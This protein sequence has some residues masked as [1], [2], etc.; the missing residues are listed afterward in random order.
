MATATDSRTPIPTLADVLARVD[1]PPGR[2]VL[3]GAIGAGTVEDVLYLNDHHGRLCELVDGILV[4]KAMGYEESGL[5]MILGHLLLVY[6]EGNPIR[7]VAGE[8]GMM[9]LVPRMV[10]IPDVSFV[11]WEQFP[12][13]PNSKGPVPAIH[14]DLAVEILSKGNTAAE[15]DRKLAEYF[16]SGTRLVWY[17][18]PPSRTVRVY[19][20]VDRVTIVDESGTLDGGEVLPGFALP[21]RDWFARA[22]RAW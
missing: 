9:T 20:A 21:V 16:Q 17:V 8:G 7:R 15:M 19:T 22:E 18:D 12:S 1:V 4:E 10:R 14:P 2:V 11:L 6:L 3:F 5:A 13:G